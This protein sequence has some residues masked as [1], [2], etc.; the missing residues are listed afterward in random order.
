MHWLRLSPL[1]C[2]VVAALLFAGGLG[3]IHPPLAASVAWLLLGFYAIRLR[4]SAEGWRQPQALVPGVL[5]LCSAVVVARLDGGLA[6]LS[7]PLFVGG[8]LLSLKLSVSDS[9][10]VHYHFGWSY[11][12]AIVAAVYHQDPF[13]RKLCDDGAVW[14][15]NSIASALSIPWA[16]SSTALGLEVAAAFVL[17][18]VLMMP[19]IEHGWRAAAVVLAAALLTLSLIVYV[20]LSWLLTEHYQQT[21]HFLTLSDPGQID[22]AGQHQPSPF[23]WVTPLAVMYP[24]SYQ[25][26]LLS[27]LMGSYT[28][29][30]GA[31]PCGAHDAS[32]SPSE[33]R[34]WRLPMA[35]AA[36]MAAV[37]LAI[38][39]CPWAQYRKLS[40][41]RICI[42]KKNLDWHAPVYGSYGDRSGGMFGQLPAHLIARG[43]RVT[44]K[45]FSAEDLQK[46][47]VLL[48]INLQERF[49]ESDR[50]RILKYVHDGGGLLIAGD[51]TGL[52]GLRE[53]ANHLVG[54]L[55][56]RL[57][58]DSAKPTSPLWVNGLEYMQHPTTRGL[59]WWMNEAN[60]WVGASLAVRL[61]AYPV[62]LGRRAF[63][64]PGNFT[65]Q[66]G[67]L[68]DMKYSCG[69]RLGDLPLV[70]AR[71]YGRG[72]IVVWGDT[73]PLQNVAW[74]FSHDYME[75]TV[76]W[77][78]HDQWH[79]PPWARVPVGLLFLAA[80]MALAVFA[81]RAFAP[82]SRA[83]VLSMAILVVAV[84]GAHVY[85]SR[86]RPETDVGSGRRA[87]ID[88]AHL[89][90]ANLDIWLR[91]GFAGLAQTLSRGQFLPYAL[92]SWKHC[93]WQPGALLILLSPMK[94]LHRL[95]QERLIVFAER[96]GHVLL[97]VGWEESAASAPLLS[98]LGL[99]L[100][101]APLGQVEGRSWLD[102]P[103]RFQN[104]WPIAL[105]PGAKARYEYRVLLR[106]KNAKCA[107]QC[108]TPQGGTITL[109][110]DSRFFRNGNLEGRFEVIDQN[111]QFLRSFLEALPG[112]RSL[113]A[114]RAK[115][116]PPADA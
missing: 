32:A 109:V 100:E 46:C 70:A 116:L 81:P 44:A 28:V 47:D 43:C 88:V 42:H 53:P 48:L 56:I 21:R 106:V 35:G 104:A 12:F 55:G 82:K 60:I 84:V 79:L 26:L 57:N 20:F 59:S 103:V 110:A 75:R 41:L 29:V 16:G 113:R 45:P 62:V 99:R 101:N 37:T 115:A 31:V 1:A 22:H 17:L 65:N 66:Q 76:A 83:R 86:Q 49:G 33:A 11:C 91:D 85:G 74:L 2:V 61:P 9:N 114:P 24:M 27:L 95:D 96:G 8:W 77:L 108:R 94:P 78:A 14:A 107:I 92:T 19:S 93:E 25:V 112:P 40:G 3:D 23:G 4:K 36:I 5:L 10:T 98:K 7:V 73:S 72:K 58:F 111:I 71:T 39:W 15:A 105:V 80:A 38:V 50:A 89:P 64:D 90:D 97:A 6:A 51:H 63:S 18:I 87:Y 69:E 52:T 30:R 67:H 102:K 68:G 34:K 54:D 13:T